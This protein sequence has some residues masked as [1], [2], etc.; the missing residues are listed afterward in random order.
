VDA[1]RVRGCLRAIEELEVAAAASAAAVWVVRR[2]NR[3][4]RR[5]EAKVC[6]SDAKVITARPNIDADPG[7]RYE[8]RSGQCGPVQGCPALGGRKGGCRVCF[9]ATNIFLPTYPPATILHVA[10]LSAYTTLR[11]MLSAPTYPSEG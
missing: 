1:E 9:A 7:S 2:F 3:K 10:A 8:L 6:G 11:P 5:R 4:R